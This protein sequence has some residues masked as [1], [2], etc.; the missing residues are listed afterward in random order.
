MINRLI[1]IDI[2]SRTCYFLDNMIII[3]NLDLNKIKICETL[4][5]NIFIYNTGYVTFKHLEYVKTYI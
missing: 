2:K 3:R 4:Y 1:K 5:Q